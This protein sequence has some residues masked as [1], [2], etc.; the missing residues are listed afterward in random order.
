MAPT[1]VLAE[2]H[3]LNLRR[4]VEPLGVGIALLTSQAKGAER[5]DIQERIRRGHVSLVIGTH[6]VIQESIAFERLGLA[7]VDEQHKFG[8]LQR[9]LLPEEGAQP[10]RPGHD[11]DADPRGPWP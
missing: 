7:I 3:H 6:A 8:V 9:G 4:L 11:G 1:E 5:D 10:G 2:Q